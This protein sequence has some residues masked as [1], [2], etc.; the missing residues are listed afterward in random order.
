MEESRHCALTGDGA[1]EFA[2][3]NGFETCEPIELITDNARELSRKH[4]YENY[5]STVEELSGRGTYD[6]V[7][8]I[9]L[10]ADGH[11]ACATSTGVF[12]KF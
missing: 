6:T 5:D 3:M 9:A 1:R 8:A 11:F 10:D 12:N 7:A 2:E 4:K